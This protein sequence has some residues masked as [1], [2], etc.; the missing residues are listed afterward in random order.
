MDVV[1]KCEAIL[2]KP[3]LYAETARMLT[4]FW[5]IPSIPRSLICATMLIVGVRLADYFA[6]QGIPIPTAVAVSAASLLLLASRY[7]HRRRSMQLEICTLLA[8][9]ITVGVVL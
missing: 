4:G 6:I 8:A 9:I 1:A 2:Q 3:R 5:K 7:F